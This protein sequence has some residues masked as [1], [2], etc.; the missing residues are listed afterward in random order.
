MLFSS[1]ILKT[2]TMNKKIHLSIIMLHWAISSSKVNIFFLWKLLSAEVSVS[3][4]LDTQLECDEAVF[5]LAGNSSTL[6]TKFWDLGF[7]DVDRYGADRKEQWW[8]CFTDQLK[9]V[10]GASSKPLGL[11]QQEL[12]FSWKEDTGIEWQLIISL[13]VWPVASFC[14]DLTFTRMEWVLCLRNCEDK[15]LWIQQCLSRTLACA[16]ALS[17]AAQPIRWSYMVWASSTCLSRKVTKLD[18]TLLP[19][20]DQSL[21]RFSRAAAHLPLWSNLLR[22][23]YLTHSSLS[24]LAVRH[25]ILTMRVN[26]KKTKDGRSSEEYVRQPEAIRVR[27][28]GAKV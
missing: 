4:T 7:H 18:L 22:L 25:N 28:E 10:S 6:A 19:M 1:P 23:Y 21:L 13:M 11:P 24:T 9:T 17:L 27:A 16:D 5:H 26:T 3:T 20:V 15:R 8:G 14:R 2:T 12:L